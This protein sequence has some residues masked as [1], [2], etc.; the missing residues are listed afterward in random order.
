LGTYRLLSLTVTHYPMP[1][2]PVICSSKADADSG[3]SIC[4]Q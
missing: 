1:P 4:F 2:E 3:L